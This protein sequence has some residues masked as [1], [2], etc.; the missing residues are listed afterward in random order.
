MAQPL[1]N[2]EELQKSLAEFQE[3]SRQMQMMASQRQQLS[4]QVEELKIAEEA[5]G[6]AEKSAIYRAIGPILIETSKADASADIKEKKDLFDMR[7]G[8]LLKQEE[9]IKPRMDEL[10]T[11]LEKAIKES[12][13]K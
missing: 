4:M 10:R 9:K 1:R 6:K 5:L 11:G 13:Q 7:I 12:R 3:L 8:M 2:Q